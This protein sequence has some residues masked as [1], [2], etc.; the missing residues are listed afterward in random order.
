VE[1]IK[2]NGYSP[3]LREIAEGVNLKS[4]STVHMYLEKLCRKGLLEINGKE[5]RAIK[6]TGYS[7]VKVL[8]LPMV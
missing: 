7:F 3:T 4:T 6:V 8:D 1:Y 2:K 5:S